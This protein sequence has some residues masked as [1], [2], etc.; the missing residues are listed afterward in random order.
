MKTFARFL[1][2]ILLLGLTPAPVYA[3]PLRSPAPQVTFELLTPLPA[4]LNL[5]ETCTVAVRITSEAEFLS[6]M[7]MPA[8]QYPGRYVVFEGNDHAGRGT[9]AVLSLTLRGKDSTTTDFPD[10]VPLAFAVAVR[11]PGGVTASQWYEFKVVVP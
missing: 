7:A 5:G 11:F 10:G 9:S 3:A 1:A 8:P 6:A 4:T 2:L